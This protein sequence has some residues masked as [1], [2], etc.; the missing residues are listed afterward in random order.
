[1]ALVLSSLKGGR[2]ASNE[3]I[4]RLVLVIGRNVDLAV[5]HVGK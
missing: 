5:E 2:A 3:A 1:M 4:Q